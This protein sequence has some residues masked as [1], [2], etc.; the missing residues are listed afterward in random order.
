MPII[1]RLARL[2]D[3]PPVSRES[4]IRSFLFF[5]A[6]EG[7]KRSEG[8]LRS[9]KGEQ[10]MVRKADI[11]GVR[12]FSGEEWVGLIAGHY[13]PKLPWHTNISIKAAATL[14][15]SALDVLCACARSR[16]PFGERG[17]RPR[18]YYYY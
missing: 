9:Q 10:G 18:R 15:V 6:V 16:G 4:S 14:N 11:V 7:E 12:L 13:L 17:S 5:E 2:L 3:A 8:G 1:R